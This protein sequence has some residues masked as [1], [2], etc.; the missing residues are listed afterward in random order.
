MADLPQDL[1]TAL[2]AVLSNAPSKELSASFQ[3]LSTRYRE[4]QAATAPIMATPTDVVTYSAYRMP[5]TFAAVRSALEQVAAV[6]PEFGPA[7]QLDLGG[8]TGAAIWAAAD[9]WPSLSAV[10]VLEQVTEAIALGKKLARGAASPAVRG[11]SWIPG[12][13]DQ[14]AAF[15]PADLV[16]VSYV[17]SELSATQ[18]QDLVAR[19]CA[20][21]GLVVLV[22]PGTPGG[23]ERI[24]AARDQLIAA[25]HSVIA[26]CPH[27]LACP[28]PRGRDWCHFTS[29]VNR[30][31]VHRR[32]K[33]AELG[34][35]D[36][37][38][39]YVVTSAVARG[40]AGNRVLRHPQ[41]RKGLVS[42][43]LCTDAGQL[44]EAIVSKR[45][46]PLY[47]AARDTEFGDPWPPLGDAGS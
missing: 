16:T 38:F 12:R 33:G 30:S 22:E 14:S 11:A 35:E 15:E 21:Q 23:Y 41:Q 1:R 26:P 6:L 9:T 2:D 10:T 36:E 40:Q 34:F 37:K 39:S 5:A 27:D 8:G 24:V 32:T 3:R 29:R 44:Q 25:G 7:N 45:Q 20:Q 47:R 13:L 4:E 43:R 18:Q 19:L 31:A 42:L 46:G 28:I 17:L